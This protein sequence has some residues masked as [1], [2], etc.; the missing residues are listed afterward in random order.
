TN[1]TTLPLYRR[2]VKGASKKT[3]RSTT[4]QMD[5][6]G[7]CGYYT[8]KTREFLNNFITFSENA[9]ILSDKRV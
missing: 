3:A 9:C 1:R 2:N 6:W 5:C 8:K 7:R 4:L